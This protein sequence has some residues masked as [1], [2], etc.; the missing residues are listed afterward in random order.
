METR[1]ILKALN[2]INKNTKEDLI[3]EITNENWN[4]Y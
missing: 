2:N 1:D 3:D 4:Y